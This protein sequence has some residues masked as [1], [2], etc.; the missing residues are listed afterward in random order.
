ME[1]NKGNIENKGIKTGS[2]VSSHV[3]DERTNRELFGARVKKCRKTLGLTQKDLAKKL[4]IDEKTLQN[5]EYGSLPKGNNLFY[6]SRA[7]KCSLDWLVTG[8]EWHAPG[9]DTTALKAE[10]PPAPEPPR[11]KGQGETQFVEAVGWLK[12][13]F[14]SNDPGVLQMILVDLKTLARGGARRETDLYK[15]L[16][17]RMDRM[18]KLL[19]ERG[20]HEYVQKKAAS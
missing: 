5:Y 12:E 2:H 11:P 4:G 13:I 15:K 1:N 17:S 9:A 7:L 16:E 10:Y 18:E 8:E 6:L 3:S 14:D 20:E 19:E